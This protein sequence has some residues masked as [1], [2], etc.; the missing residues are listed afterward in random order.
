MKNAVLV[1]GRPNK[2]EHY[3]PSLPANSDDHWFPW[4]S[5]QLILKDIHAVVIEPPF[6]FAPRY[7]AWKKEFE[8]FDIS[9]ETILVG[10][11]CGGGF[12]V[13][14]LSENKST[15][16]GKV[17]LVAPWLNPENNPDSGTA[18]FFEFDIDSSIP[19]RTKGFTIFS[20]DNDQETIKKS[21]EILK[22]K[23]SDVKIIEF[24]DY[25]HF[26]YENMKTREFPEL[27]EEVLA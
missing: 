16:V 14:W 25:G 1:P 4:L 13:R 23:I 19:D 26:C 3:D 15:T 22:A 12:L 8:R 17:V 7:D 6:P 21:V 10:H 11:S 27:L 2:D 18:D 20:S 24:H 5:R 9:D